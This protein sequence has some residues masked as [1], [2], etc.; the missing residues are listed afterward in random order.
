MNATTVQKIGQT[1]TRNRGM[2]KF[3]N[4]LSDTFQSLSAVVAV[5]AAEPAAPVVA[6]RDGDL[7]E[8]C[9]ALFAR[10]LGAMVDVN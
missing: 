3:E 5:G 10:L 9:V 4:E 1:T 8:E 2:K 6:L 7:D